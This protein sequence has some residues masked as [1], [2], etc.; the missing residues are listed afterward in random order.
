MSSH[1]SNTLPGDHSRPWL[2]W[3][4][5]SSL[6]PP[7]FPGSLFQA[8]K[9]YPGHRMSEDHEKQANGTGQNK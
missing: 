6:F 3:Q 8:A 9:P 4:Y 5:E 2:T 1:P 7:L